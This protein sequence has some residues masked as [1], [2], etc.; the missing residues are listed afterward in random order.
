[1]TL[2]VAYLVGSASEDSLNRRLAGALR[3]AAPSSIEFVEARIADLP[4]YRPE[5]D[6]DFPETGTR[7]KSTI[8]E[9]DGV[10]MVTPEY[11]R[12]IPAVLRNALDWLSRPRGENSLAGKPVMLAGAT[13]GAIG[14]AVAQAE[15][16][17]VLGF[18]N[19]RL[20]GQPELYIRISKDQFDEDGRAATPGTQDFL[21]S[22]MQAFAEHIEGGRAWQKG[23]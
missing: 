2:T 15:L 19:A 23:A 11:N 21:A 8:A 4:F 14:T 18:F 7:L 22:A 6:A 16:R 12:S 10:L 9:A 13:P 1:M 3:L 5:F 17:S 20:M